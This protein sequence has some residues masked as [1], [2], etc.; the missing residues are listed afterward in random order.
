MKNS[1]TRLARSEQ[2]I[3]DVIWSVQ[4]VK[5]LQMSMIIEALELLNDGRKSVKMQQDAIEW[6][7]HKSSH[8]FSFDTC[9]AANDLNPDHLRW[10]LNKILD[11][12]LYE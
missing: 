9:C 6:V 1:T 10:M 2:H 7:A 12:G 11:G 3:K 8:P 4:H 5:E